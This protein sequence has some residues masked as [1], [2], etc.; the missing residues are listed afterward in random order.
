MVAEHR[1]AFQLKSER[2][3]VDGTGFRNA[4]LARIP[5]DTVF[6]NLENAKV[7]DAGIQSLPELV[8]LRC[9][10]LDSTEITDSAL[11][12]VA[13]FGS[14]EELWLENTAVTDTGLA[15]LFSLKKLRFISLVDCAISDAAAE[16]LRQAMPGLEVH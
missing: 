16:L 2:G 7:T 10:D 12:K 3:Y 11:H 5:R 4:D 8:D 1:L 14:L 9:L 13:S 15:F 6:L